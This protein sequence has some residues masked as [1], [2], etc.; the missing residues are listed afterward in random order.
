[1][2]LGKNHVFRFH[3]PEQARSLDKPGQP[4]GKEQ[5]SPCREESGQG[6]DQ[7]DWDFAHSELLEREGVDLKVILF[8]SSCS[9]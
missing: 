8:S 4:E 5:L 7:A 2:I 1:V 9:C 3:H 6:G